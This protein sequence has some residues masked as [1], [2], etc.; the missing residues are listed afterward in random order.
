M[1][2][3]AWIVVV[4]AALAISNWSL[5]YVARSWHVVPAL[6]WTVS[7][8][9][10]GAALLC[11]D[12][13]LKAARLGDST[14][15]PNTGLVLLASLSAWL[16]SYHAQLSGDPWQARVL[17]A[18]P[19]VIAV[20]M[21]EFQLRHDRRAALREAGRVAEPLPPFGGTTWFHHP[22]RSWEAQRD[23]TGYR[24]GVK[25]RSSMASPSGARVAVGEGPSR[26]QLAGS[27][28]RVTAMATFD[29]A[30]IR[31]AEI[32]IRDDL[33]NRPGEVS[34]RKSAARYT[35]TEYQAETMIKVLRAEMNGHR[36]AREEWPA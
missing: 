2:Q 12:L 1:R 14:F 18:A 35:I 6:S 16:N 3:A 23:I 30:A 7:V 31:T 29:S 5:A 21:T 33:V 22:L 8:V 26:R 15:G 13:A 27:R 11:A 9:F 25:R 28:K 34:K 17:F 20:A 10:D 32:G 36:D 19:P 24:L 4:T